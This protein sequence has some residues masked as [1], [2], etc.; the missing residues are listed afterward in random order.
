MSVKSMF[1][2]D[3]VAAGIAVGTI[4]LLLVF[5]YALHMNVQGLSREIEELKAL[6]KEVLEL[7]ARHA[8]L[9]GKVT[10][11]ASLPRRTVVMTMENQVRAMAHATQDLDRRLDGRHRDKLK[12]IQELLEEIGDDLDESK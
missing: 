3:R 1:G 6:N 2:R 10:E 11:L 8:V 7:D 4:L 12:V 5:F 9:D